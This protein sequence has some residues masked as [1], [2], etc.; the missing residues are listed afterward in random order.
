M[1]VADIFTKSLGTEKSQKFRNSLGVMH[2]D[3][4]L[5]GSVAP[6]RHRMSVHL[7]DLGDG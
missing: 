3:M 6:H 4:S 1:Q 2:L 5:R 7:D